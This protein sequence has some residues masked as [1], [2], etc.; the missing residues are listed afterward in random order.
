MN[1]IGA[2]DWMKRLILIFKSDWEGEK[3]PNNFDAAP[4][5]QSST[6]ALGWHGKLTELPLWLQL[7]ACFTT[8][9]R[10]IAAKRKNFHVIF[11]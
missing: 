7:V 2:L 3:L 5:K 1:Y 6:C 8:G 9:L 4:A 11:R 10:V